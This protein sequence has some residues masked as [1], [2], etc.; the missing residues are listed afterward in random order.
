MLGLK[1]KSLRESCVSYHVLYVRRGLA[2]VFLVFFKKKIN[3]H[4]HDDF[5]LGLVTHYCSRS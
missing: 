1:K 4:G 5:Q 2:A 3:V